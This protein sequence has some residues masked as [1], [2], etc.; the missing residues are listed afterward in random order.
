MNDTRCWMQSGRRKAVT[1]NREFKSPDRGQQTEVNRTLTP[2]RQTLIERIDAALAS[3]RRS[4]YDLAHELYPNSKS[5]RRQA[6]GGPPGCYMAL[7][8]AIRR[9]GFGES[10]REPGP[11]NRWIYQRAK[12]KRGEPHY[13][14]LT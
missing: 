9:G 7:S 14:D 6:N 3:G 13:H 11:Q 1:P 4:F 5:H 8:A 10:W 2:M 12:P